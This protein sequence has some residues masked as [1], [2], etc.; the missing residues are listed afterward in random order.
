[1]VPSSATSFRPCEDALDEETPLGP[2]GVD[3]DLTTAIEAVAASADVPDCLK[4]VLMA[5][6][7]NLNKVMANKDKEISELRIENDH[8]RKQL[9]LLED[10]LSVAHSQSMN[11]NSCF[12]PIDTASSKTGVESIVNDPPN[13]TF[14][15]ESCNQCSESERLRSLVFIGVPELHSLSNRDRIDHDLNGVRDIL[16]FLHVQCDPVTVYRLGKPMTD[17][18]RKLKVVLPAR[19]FQNMTLQR[20]HRLRFFSKWRVFIRPSLPINERKRSRDTRSTSLPASV[21]QSSVVVQPSQGGGQA[22]IAGPAGMKR[23]FLKE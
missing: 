6:V 18:S 5:I 19:V 7:V 9:S 8:L 14:F 12:P 15:R 13:S 2:E 16:D 10:K 21:A 11:L 22:F 17:R 4:K 3:F 1:M 20:C 23:S